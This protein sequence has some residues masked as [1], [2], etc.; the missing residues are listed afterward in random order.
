MHTLV[1]VCVLRQGVFVTYCSKY[2][3]VNEANQ[4]RRN[5]FVFKQNVPAFI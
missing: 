1:H 5:N 4:L 2:K 3:M